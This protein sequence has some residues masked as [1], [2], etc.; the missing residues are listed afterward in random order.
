MV[1]VRRPG[2]DE[3]MGLEPGQAPQTEDEEQRS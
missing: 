3:P 1:E 2:D